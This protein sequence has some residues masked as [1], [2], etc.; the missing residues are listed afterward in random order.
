M[1]SY[2]NIKSKDGGFVVRCEFGLPTLQT[3]ELLFPD[4]SH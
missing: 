4:S 3:R 1:S 2:S